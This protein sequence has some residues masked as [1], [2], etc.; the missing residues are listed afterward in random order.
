MQRIPILCFD[1]ITYLSKK[2][3]EQDFFGQL[4]A[5]G[6]GEFVKCAM[7]GM[8]DGLKASNVALQVCPCLFLSA[9]SKVKVILFDPIECDIRTYM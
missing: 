4:R 9:R 6:S 8:S 3:N 2:K 7:D 5:S 1:C